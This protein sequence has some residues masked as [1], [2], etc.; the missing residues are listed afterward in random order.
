MWMT[1]SIDFSDTGATRRQSTSSS[2]SN[3]KKTPAATTTSRT[4]FISSKTTARTSSSFPPGA[5]TFLSPG[6]RTTHAATSLSMLSAAAQTRSPPTGT[7]QSSGIE[8]S[9]YTRLPSDRD[10]ASHTEEEDLLDDDADDMAGLPSGNPVGLVVP[11]TQFTLPPTPQSTVP[12]EWDG[13][14]P[15]VC[16]K[17]FK[18]IKNDILQPLGLREFYKSYSSWEK[19]SY[20][21]RN[22]ALSWFRSLPENWQGLYFSSCIAFYFVY[23]LLN[24]FFLLFQNTFSG[25]QG[26]LLQ[27]R[28][29][30]TLLL[31]VIPQK[32][33]SST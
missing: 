31:I 3:R 32:T 13:I 27:Q 10:D 17:C 29:K 2:A 11:E 12:P 30:M 18:A 33:T 19:M 26:Q 24:Y 22:K 8:D 20:D 5:S 7:S 28:R 23:C 15:D 6:I 9:Q 4:V 25:R 14:N 21:Q 16:M 1:R